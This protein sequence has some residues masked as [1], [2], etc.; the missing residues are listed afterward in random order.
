M[1]WK[2]AATTVAICGG[3][4]IDGNSR[5]AEAPQRG[6]PPAKSPAENSSLTG[7][8]VFSIEAR[9]E[10]LMVSRGKMTQAETA[11]TGSCQNLTIRGAL[12]GSHISLSWFQSG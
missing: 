4:W 6:A 5:T 3:M 10:S 9:G 2:L 1:Y 8:W 7:D 12:D 11:V